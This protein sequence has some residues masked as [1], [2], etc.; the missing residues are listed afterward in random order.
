MAKLNI[1]IGSSA[2]DKTG[3]PLRTAFSKV[4][5]NFTELYSGGLIPTQTGN[6][7]KFLTTSGTVLS[8]SD[9]S[10]QSKAVRNV[11]SVAAAGTVTLDYS[12]DSV[13]RATATG[14]TITI[15][16]S[17]ITSGK[18]VELILSNTSGAA[19]T[20]TVGVAGTNTINNSTTYAIGNNTTHIFT[21]RSFGTTTTDVYVTVV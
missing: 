17:T 3:D 5:A 19:C 13:V 4:N 20:V 1:N 9:P 14:S 7:G 15:A 6:G 11:G 8:W 12:T 2:N 16:H 21:G 18:V 10:L